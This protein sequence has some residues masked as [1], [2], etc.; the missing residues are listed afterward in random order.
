MRNIYVV[1]GVLGFVFGVVLKERGWEGEDIGINSLVVC[2]VW[3]F[4]RCEVC[5]V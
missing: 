5:G 3:K 1:G 2:F 4:F